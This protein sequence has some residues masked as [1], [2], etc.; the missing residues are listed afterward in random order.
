MPSRWATE[1]QGEESTVQGWEN[2]GVPATSLCQSSQTSL[3][4]RFRSEE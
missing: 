3:G 4:L 1:A 2:P